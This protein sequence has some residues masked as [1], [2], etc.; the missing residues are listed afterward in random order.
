MALASASFSLALA[1]DLSTVA[2]LADS[3]TD[4]KNRRGREMK[5]ALTIHSKLHIKAILKKRREMS[6]I[7]ANK[8]CHFGQ[9]PYRHCV[10]NY[11]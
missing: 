5:I 1:E 7:V 3:L 6:R 9:S 11:I 8:K 4:K 2:D 10:M